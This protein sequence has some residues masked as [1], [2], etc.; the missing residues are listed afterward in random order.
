[1]L[2]HYRRVRIGAGDTCT[3][4]MPCVLLVFVL[5]LAGQIN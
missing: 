5:I 1:M 2:H 4:E 3:N